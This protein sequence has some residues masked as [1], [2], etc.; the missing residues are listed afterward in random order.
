MVRFNHIRLKCLPAASLTYAR[1]Y[2]M[3]LISYYPEGLSGKFDSLR[4]A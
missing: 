2:D 4:A 1:T 3:S